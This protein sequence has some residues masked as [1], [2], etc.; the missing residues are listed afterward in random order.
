[1]SVIGQSKYEPV[2][3][4]VVRATGADAAVV[5]ILNGPQGTGAAAAF[6]FEERTPAMIRATVRLLRLVAD[7]MEADLQVL[8]KKAGVT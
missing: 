6:T 5:V 3:I 1:V 7:E 8:G 4:G 2:A